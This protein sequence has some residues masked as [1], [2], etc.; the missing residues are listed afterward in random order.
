MNTLQLTLFPTPRT[1]WPLAVRRW[2]REANAAPD[3]Y[4]TKQRL[5]YPLKDQLLHQ[6]GKFI[7]WDTQRIRL[8]CNRC[9]GAGRFHYWYDDGGE[10]CWKC[11]GTGTYKYAFHLLER[12]ILWGSI[13]HRPTI[14][15]RVNQLGVFHHHYKGHLKHGDINPFQG[16]RALMMLLLLFRPRLFFVEMK[17]RIH[18][19]ATQRIMKID[20]WIRYRNEGELPF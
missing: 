2:M 3:Y 19:R 5:F 4:Y 11:G 7:G 9:D 15:Q 8:I 16:E 18:E 14:I 20:S 13:Y 10:T 6:Y 17:K 1:W 12:W